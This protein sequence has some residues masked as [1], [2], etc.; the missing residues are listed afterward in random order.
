MTALPPLRIAPSILSADFGR[1]A[2]EIRAVE[3]AGAD[4]IHVDVMDGRFVPN[5]TLGPVIVE[6]ARRA[7]SLPLDVHLMIENP[8]RYVDAFAKAGANT[9]S[10][11]MEA[12]PHLHRVLQQIAAAGAQPAVALNPHT[13]LDGLEYVLEDCAL[14]LI[15]SVNPGF[16][17]QKYI[18]SAARKI[19]LLRE[20]AD[21]RGLKNL[22]IEV[23]GGIGP[24]T[25]LEVAKAGADT[26]VAGSAVFG[27]KD[28]RGAIDAIRQSA[29]QGRAQFGR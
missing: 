11:H 4:V 27:T 21:A 20:M 22:A 6:A 19:A 7:T 24:L 14:V 18:P 25:A 26:L 23:D 13:P 8:E 10:V 16:G 3:E 2:E 29:L 15:M 1:L 17:G 12:C 5:I 9:I 28:Y